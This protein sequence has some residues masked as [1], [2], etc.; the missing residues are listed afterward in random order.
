MLYFLSQCKYSL[1]VALIYCVCVTGWNREEVKKEVFVC[2]RV[3]MWENVMW[4]TG[5]RVL[6]MNLLFVLWNTS[7]L[8]QVQLV[9]IST[10]KQEVGGSFPKLKWPFKLC[11][12]LQRHRES[13]QFTNIF[14]EKYYTQS[15][16]RLC[17]LCVL[18]FMHTVCV[19][20]KDWC[21]E[22]LE[23]DYAHRNKAKS[24]MCVFICANGCLWEHEYISANNRWFLPANRPWPTPPA[25]CILLSFTLDTHTHTYCTYMHTY[26]HVYTHAPPFSW[27]P[28]LH[29]R[30]LTT[31][32]A[33]IW[34]DWEADLCF[35]V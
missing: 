32:I 16:W 23:F 19:F 13:T 12:H 26:T 35:K 14:I 33:V 20:S 28:P 31:S 4:F 10:V 11:G 34:W 30:V 18:A 24:D 6:C 1:T 21:S 8:V 9:Y 2:P 15:L 7:V 25:T 29:T 17:V 3:W 27:N 22:H 5:R